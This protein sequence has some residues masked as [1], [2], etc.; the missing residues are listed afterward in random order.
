M[1]LLL[2]SQLNL[3]STRKKKNK[4]ETQLLVQ[5]IA[6]FVLT[7]SNLLTVL[8]VRKLTR[9]VSNVRRAVDIQ[10]EQQRLGMRHQFGVIKE[11][12]N[13]VKTIIPKK[14]STVE[15][16]TLAMTELLENNK[17]NQ[18]VFGGLTA[19]TGDQLQRIAALNDP[20]RQRQPADAKFITEL[21]E[22]PKKYILGAGIEAVENKMSKEDAEQV[23]R[24]YATEQTIEAAEKLMKQKKAKK[25][26]GL[27]KIEP[28]T[29]E[30]DKN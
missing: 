24:D 20:S 17:A 6:L 16:L 18:Y 10:F 29:I 7:V 11:R 26:S 4:M 2:V 28:S 13:H 27:S 23:L 22:T 12:I 5:S 3:I 30:D 15:E 9:Q 8:T 19:S 1:T 25:P 14:E 21:Y